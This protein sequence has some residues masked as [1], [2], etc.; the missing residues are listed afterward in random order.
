MLN[1]TKNVYIRYVCIIFNISMSCKKTTKE[2][3]T[4]CLYVTS[5]PIYPLAYCNFLKSLIPVMKI[6]QGCFNSLNISNS[7]W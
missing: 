5:E 4:T 2:Y 3:N 1:L 6:E 7:S